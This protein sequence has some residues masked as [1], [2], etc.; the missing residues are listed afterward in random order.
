MFLPWIK[1]LSERK[2]SCH[3]AQ[4][5]APVWRAQV[6]FY[7]LWW[8]FLG[9]RSTKYWI[10]PAE[11]MCLLSILV[12][13]QQWNDVFSV[14]FQMLDA[15]ISLNRPH[16]CNLLDLYFMRLPVKQCAVGKSS[17]P[18]RSIVLSLLFCSRSID[19][20]THSY[21]AVTS[22]LILVLVG[23][24]E[25]ST[26][27]NKVMKHTQSARRIS[28]SFVLIMSSCPRHTTSE[29][30]LCFPF[31]LCVSLLLPCENTA[32]FQFPFLW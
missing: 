17:W 16:S 25:A 24:I 10:S 12:R 29:F 28:N 1:H 27:I 6:S 23:G 4:S 20:T 18:V 19:D 14:A 7:L 2:T 22:F 13:L 21:D 11:F 5:A 9:L 8:L 26:K 15:S 32:F 3:V 31:L 30:C